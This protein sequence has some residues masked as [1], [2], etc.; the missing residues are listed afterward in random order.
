MTS[1]AWVL[2]LEGGGGVRG[3]SGCGRRW[4]VIEKGGGKVVGG[5]GR[6]TEEEG[7]RT[8]RGFGY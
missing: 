6:R 2:L 1:L 8:C 7:R 3:K 4:L 5:R